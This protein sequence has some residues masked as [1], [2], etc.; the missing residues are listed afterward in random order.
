MPAM[1]AFKMFTLGCLLMFSAV[2]IVG[3]SETLGV[4]LAFAALAMWLAALIRVFIA[5]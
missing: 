3:A 2:G 4:A 5:S 1:S